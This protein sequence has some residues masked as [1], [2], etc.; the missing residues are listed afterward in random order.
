MELK[1]RKYMPSRFVFNILLLLI[2]VAVVIG[3]VIMITI[4]SRYMLIAEAI[5]QITV[6]VVI[7]ASN[8]NPDYKAPWI[9]FVLIV[10][11]VGFMFYFMFYSR[12]LNPV[13]R[14]KL[15]RID[16]GSA[17]LCDSPDAERLAEESPHAYS[18]AALLKKLSRTHIY[19][20]TEVTYFPLGDSMF[21]AMIEDLKKAEK[22]IFLEYFIIQD[23]KFW[24]AILD[25]LTQKAR[26]GVD[27]R[28][29]Y[30][31]IG[32]MRTLPGNYYKT[33][34]KAGIKCATFS[35]L[36]AQANNKFNNRSHRKITV[37]DGIVG[38]TGGINLADEYI[39]A[40]KRFGHWKDVGIRIEGNAVNELTRLFFEDY[41][42]NSSHVDDV[43]EFYRDELRPT[44][45]GYVVPFGDG[46]KPVYSHTVAKTAIMNLLNQAKRYVYM[47]SPYLI[48]DS[49]LTQAIENA[50]LRGVD[51][52]LITPHI[53]DKKLVFT[54][55][56]SYYPR[57]I[58]A[59][60]KIYE[61]T[62]G[63]VHAKM[64]IADGDAAILGTVNLDYRSL[65]HHF[66][67]AVWLYNVPAIADM[68][69]DFL[70]TQ[71][72]SEQVDEQT[73][74]VRLPGKFV[75]AVVKIFAPLL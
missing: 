31:D 58:E 34:R 43:S 29:L 71:E 38:Y 18:Q 73:A 48:I 7:I 8:D 59:G 45:Q 5:T 64:Y 56:R 25:V 16:A 15:R 37:I 12:K 22:F 66:E 61:Y 9:F 32:C 11:V 27:V 46:P 20:D 63:F 54:M 62:P 6:A 68:E 70:A 24:R 33:L 53:P 41:E 4:G 42:L 67:N 19:T 57:L 36:R 55:T 47:T 3:L 1:Y 69:R 44:R 52:R 30:D 51:V 65:V 35:H 60:V 23:G 40:R 10:P 28:V 50:A 49:E 14:R 17:K 39:N 2:E 72:R 74:E 75:R 21:P 13:S 26:A